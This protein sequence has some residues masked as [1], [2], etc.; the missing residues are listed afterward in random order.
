MPG[1]HYARL[2]YTTSNLGD[3][4]QTVATLPFL[5]HTSYSFN[6]DTLAL[7]KSDEQYIII[8]NAWWAAVPEKAFPPAGCFLPVFIGFHLTQSSVAYFSRTHCVDYLK[9]HAPIG[10]RDIA[11]INIL[12]TWSVETFFSGCLT[13]TFQRRESEPVTGKIF[14]VDTERVNYLIPSIF[15]EGAVQVTHQYT[16]DSANREKAVEDLLH[17]Y[18]TSASLIITTRLHAALTCSAMGIPVVFFFHPDDPRATTAEQIGL[19]M[20]KYF[21]IQP[22]WLKKGMIKFHI[23][24][25]WTWFEKVIFW[26][27]YTFFQKIEWNPQPLSFEGHKNKLIDKTREMIQIQLNRFN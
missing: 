10:C 27:K 19:S 11:T 1:I 24:F 22:G 6:R 18:R 17:Q 4:I 9:A 25:L 26:T 7:E 12:K 2:T 13:T 15:K 23:T 21:L 16:G 8:M 14:L 5:N 20:H 3:D